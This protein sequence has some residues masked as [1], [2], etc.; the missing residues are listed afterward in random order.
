MPRKYDGKKDKRHTI[1]LLGP[2]KAGKTTLACNLFGK[3][4]TVVL[5]YDV[6]GL[7]VVDD[8]DALIIDPM[9][10]WEDTMEAL[11]VLKKEYS[12]KTTIVVNDITTCGMLFLRNAPQSRDPR[13]TYGIAIDQ[14][15]QLVE[16][17]KFDFPTYHVI[18]EAVDMY[19]EDEQEAVIFTYPN[20]IGRYTFAQQLPGMV[21]H[22]FY[23]VPPKIK[24]TVDSKG[25]VTKEVERV[26]LTQTDGIKLAGNRVNVAGKEP[27]LELTEKVSIEDGVDNIA[28][29]RKKLLGG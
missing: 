22:V 24:K 28:R 27:I 1:L 23:V 26:I 20:V 29:L 19:L 4:N 6:D 16:K 17:L 15:R 10:A 11:R 21:D 2:P 9:N 13:R 3:E 14:L 12:K 25:K 8:V 18:F 7:K 5:A